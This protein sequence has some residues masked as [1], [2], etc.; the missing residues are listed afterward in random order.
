LLGESRQS[1]GDVAVGNDE[2]RIGIQFVPRLQVLGVECPDVSLENPCLRCEQIA[3]LCGKAR[4]DRQ[5]LAT[6][7]WFFHVERSARYGR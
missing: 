4:T 6:G 1:V 5:A 3:E 2:G 7:P